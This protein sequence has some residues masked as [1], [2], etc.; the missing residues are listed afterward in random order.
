[1]AS[2]EGIS[3]D[4]VRNMYVNIVVHYKGKISARDLKLMPSRRYNAGFTRPWTP[5]VQPW[6][7]IIHLFRCK[8]P[9]AAS[10]RTRVEKKRTQSNN[11]SKYANVRTHEYHNRSVSYGSHSSDPAHRETLPPLDL[12]QEL[13]RTP[14]DAICTGPRS[15]EVNK[16]REE[17]EGTSKVTPS[18][19]SPLPESPASHHP[20]S[21]PLSIL[22][23][24][25]CPKHRSSSE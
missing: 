10:S 2:Y 24:V 21:S 25:A 6:H 8:Q 17:K 7:Y 15:K 16:L 3:V 14:A 5:H 11:R 1:M 12:S 22:A 18:S 9:W 4:T 19:I 20:S 23:L 13:V